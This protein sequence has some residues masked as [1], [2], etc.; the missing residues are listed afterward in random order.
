MLAKGVKQ[1]SSASQSF[2]ESQIAELTKAFHRGAAAASSALGQWLN[3]N[4]QMAVDGVDLCPLSAAIGVLGDGDLS[5]CMSLMEMRGS[6]SGHM[7]L[8]FDDAS[9]LAL[10]DLLLGRA[11]GTGHEW[12]EVEISCVQE[13]MNIAG[14]AYFSGV[15]KDLTARAKTKVELVPSPPLF[16]RDFAESLL[17]S[18]FMDQALASSDVLFARTRF[19]LADQPLRW[20]FLLIPDPPSLGRLSELLTVRS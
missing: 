20:T 1:V 9:G 17:E 2:D 7:L 16:L 12:G 18:A 14:S 4:V 10:S 19:D 5:I 15:A 6:L 11:S 13:T 8:A 3:A